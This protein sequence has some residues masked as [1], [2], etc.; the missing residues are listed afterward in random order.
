M[1][2]IS[3]TLHGYLDYVTVIL[4]VIAPTFFGLTGAAGILAY[5]LAGIHL[6]ITLLTDFPLGVAKLIPFTIH[7]WIERIV[8]PVLVLLPFGLG[9]DGLAQIFYIV[10]GVII[11]TVGLLT[12][13]QRT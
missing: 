10:V 7:G 2:I 3:P 13:Y 5:A 12:D 9:F 11:I 8:G 6:T 4:F 1:K